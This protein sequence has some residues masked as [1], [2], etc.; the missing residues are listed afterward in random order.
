MVLLG[1]GDGA[2]EALEEFL[3]HGSSG[4]DVTFLKN[5]GKNRYVT[6]FTLS[7]ENQLFWVDM[8]VGLEGLELVQTPETVVVDISATVRGVLQRLYSYRA[9]HASVHRT[10]L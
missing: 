6:T 8:R 10:Y 3:Q 4:A 9:V 7:R 5:E 1:I 2:P